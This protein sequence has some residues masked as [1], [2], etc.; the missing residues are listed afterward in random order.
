MIFNSKPDNEQTKSNSLVAAAT[1]PLDLIPL[2][3]N[4]L[5]LDTPPNGWVLHLERRGIAVLT[6]DIGRRAISRSDAKQ[7]LDEKHANEVRQAK[8][9]AL[10]EQEMVEAD[11]RFR[12][13]L[14]QGV[15]ADLIPAGSTYMEAVVAAQLDAQPYRPRRSTVAEDLLSG[16]GYVFH[17]I[18]RDA[19]EEL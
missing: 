9:R 2:S 11:Q 14:G 6:D 19:D 3:H 12:A 18:E 8:L 15:P 16:G 1:T 7:L 13:S 17:P 5:E 4:G 10:Q